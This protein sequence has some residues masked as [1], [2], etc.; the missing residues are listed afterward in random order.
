MN[1]LPS[2]TMLFGFM[3]NFV[4]KSTYSIYMLGNKLSKSLLSKEKHFWA[5]WNY[6]S[7]D[8]NEHKC[9]RISNKYVR[10]RGGTISNFGSISR[11][12]FF[13]IKISISISISIVSLPK[14]QDQDQYQD[15]YFSW[16]QYQYQDQYLPKSKIN[17]NIDINISKYWYWYRK[18][19][20]LNACFVFQ[21]L[22]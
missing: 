3:P 12:I 20:I 18:I 21:Q 8:P 5:F 9:S 4:L 22:S 6:I 11:S 16:C 14:N 13:Q 2:M 7:C 10:S 1:I 17:I 19:N 15:Q